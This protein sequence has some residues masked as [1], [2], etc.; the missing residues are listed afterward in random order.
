M[1]MPLNDLTGSKFGRLTVIERA[2]NGSKGSR[3]RC[4]CDCGGERIVAASNLRTGSVK[5][6]GCWRRER[7]RKNRTHGE[8][9]S[10]TTIKSKEYRAWNGAR[11]RCNN[12]RD[13]NF[14]NYGG[15]GVKFLYASFEAFLADLGRSTPGTTLDRI[16]NDGNYEPGNCRWATIE[17][18]NA[19]K[20]RGNQWTARLKDRSAKPERLRAR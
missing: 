13:R 5:S 3:W 16:D 12:P 20:R 10:G 19:N 8:S 14:K 11:N 4:V 7:S 15:R 9:G 17:E 18:Q 6:C 1:P 2:A